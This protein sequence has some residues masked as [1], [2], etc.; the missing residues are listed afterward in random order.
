M[1]RVTPFLAI[2]FLITLFSACCSVKKAEKAPS[3]Q[4]SLA[5]GPTVIIYKTMKDYS[6]LVPIILSDDKKTL[7]SYPG[8]KDVFFNDSLAYPTKLH[9]GYW[10]DNR[11]INKNVAFINLTYEAFAKLPMTPSAE[12]LM[13]MI[14]DRQPVI[15]M[16]SCGNRSS[17]K[18]IVLELNTR[19]DA[20]DFSAFKK[21]K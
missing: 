12:E 1:G 8:I 20:G 14:I 9:N 17:Y 16:Y 19:I 7:E 11:G 13:N 18:D 5:V 21:I 6:K 15:G 2:L 10:L 3:A 4:A